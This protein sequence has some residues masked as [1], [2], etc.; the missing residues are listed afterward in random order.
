MMEVKHI[1]SKDLVSIAKEHEYF[2]WHLVTKK[3]FNQVLYSYFESYDNIIHHAVRDVLSMVDVPYFESYIDDEVD[4]II[5][6]KDGFAKKIHS[7]TNKPS[8]VMIGFHRTN[9]IVS[10]WEGICYCPEGMIELIYKT[11]PNFFKDLNLD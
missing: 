7:V 1:S 10:T 9:P 2:I 4:F 5:N 3:Y 6:L 8:P 11:N